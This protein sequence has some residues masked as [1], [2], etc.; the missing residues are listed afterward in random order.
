[1]LGVFFYTGSV[2][3]AVLAISVSLTLCVLEYAEAHFI[4]AKEVPRK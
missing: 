3:L 4:H 1:M 2:R